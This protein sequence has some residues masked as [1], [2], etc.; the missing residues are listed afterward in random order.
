MNSN[1]KE[2]QLYFTSPNKNQKELKKLVL[3]I[4]SEFQSFLKKSENEFFSNINTKSYDEIKN[5]F[6][7]FIARLIEISIHNSQGQGSESF[8]SNQ[9]VFNRQRPAQAVASS[10]ENRKTPDQ[11]IQKFLGDYHFTSISRNSS[12]LRDTKLKPLTYETKNTTIKSSLEKGRNGKI[13]FDIEIQKLE[14]TLKKLTKENIDV[15]V[16]IQYLENKKT[17]KLSKEEEKKLS[18]NLTKLQRI[19]TKLS[20]SIIN[21][22]M[23]IET[24][25]RLKT[26][27]E[28]KKPAQSAQLNKNAEE[29][30]RVE[31][32]LESFM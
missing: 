21:L 22:N 3:S 29:R 12:N 19:E 26:E 5:K 20:T 2:C 23:Y 6:N 7:K 25:K 11:M 17:N 18:Y 32:A 31:N 28:N 30:K 1:I 27:S 4:V 10:A 14:D 24:I 13:L 16:C 8:S 9:G 15:N